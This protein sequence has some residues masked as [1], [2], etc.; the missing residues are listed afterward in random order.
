LEGQ[1]QGKRH[2]Q[3]DFLVSGLGLLLHLDDVAAADVADVAGHVQE[4][5]G[6]DLQCGHAMEGCSAFR[7]A[8]AQNL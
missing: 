6:G 8:V 4:A 5:N 2:V 1:L 7:G 3:D